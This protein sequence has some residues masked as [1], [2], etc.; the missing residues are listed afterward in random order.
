[1]V[2]LHLSQSHPVRMSG[3]RQRPQLV[4]IVVDCWLRQPTKLCPDNLITSVATDHNRNRP[5][6]SATK[7]YLILVDELFYI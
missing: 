7:T 6:I 1:M 2:F 5:N 4:W 3:L